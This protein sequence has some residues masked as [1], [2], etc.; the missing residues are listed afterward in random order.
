[1]PSV[2]A[3][4]ETEE[5]LKLA[6]RYGR[7]SATAAIRTALDYMRK[8]PPLPED[9]LTATEKAIELAKSILAEAGGLKRVINA[10][11]VV[12]HTNLGRA[13]LSG[14]AI[15]AASSAA[16]GY[17]DLEYDLTSG[18]RGSRQAHVA[19]ILAGLLGAEAAMIVNNN[20]A[21]VL[22]CLDALAKGGRVAVS[23]GE[24][25]EIGGSFRVPEIIQATGAQLVEVGTTNRTKPADYEKAAG[26]GISAIL[27]VHPSNFRVSGFV[28][29]TG[30]EELAQIAHRHSVPLIFDVGS[31][32]LYDLSA[33]GL[34]PEPGPATALAEGADLVTFS[35]DKLP[36][37]PQCGI[38][39]GRA[40][41]MA[42]LSKSPLA[43]AFRV[44]KMRIAALCATIRQHSD[45]SA[46]EDIPAIAMI[47]APHE[48]L[49]E[50]A[51]EIAG[52]LSREA[53]AHGL[54]GF[55]A[56]ACDTA[57]EVGGGSV[58]GATLR[59]AGARVRVKGL[60]S[61]VIASRLRMG[62]PAVVA[63]ERE[64]FLV[65]AVRTVRDNE[66]EE[67]VRAVI[68]ASEE[69]GEGA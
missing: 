37:G 63:L 29:E 5:G 41:L 23:R 2:S 53:T 14:L 47:K 54:D 62:R 45:K 64:G 34:P 4:V 67:L 16:S 24:L 33:Y 42:K 50:K 18:R 35:A 68:D 39:A 55:E 7:G 65:I 28:S 40:D 8:S 30:V 6:A 9:R 52:K 69:K 3:V 27:K 58:P 21:A 44:D 38:I 31:G 56:A 1:M 43:R 22:L 11:G 49:M 26:E 66:V 12:L 15:E 46:I 19:G 48:K 17:S 36:G 25:V 59:G 61:S 57:D 51:R 32:A 13:P 20:A 60:T 10:T